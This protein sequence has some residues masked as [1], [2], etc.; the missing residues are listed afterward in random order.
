MAVARIFDRERMQVEFRLHQFERAR[1]RVEQR[2]PD[3]AIG[4]DQIVDGCPRLDVRELLARSDTRR[5]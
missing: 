2:D 3:E 4:L 1:V 5:S